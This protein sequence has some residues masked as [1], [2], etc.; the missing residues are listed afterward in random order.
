MRRPQRA[1]APGHDAGGSARWLLTYSD[2]ITLLL[3][4]FVILYAVSKIDAKRYEAVVLAIHGVFKGNT[5]YPTTARGDRAPTPAA[6]RDLGLELMQ[7]L[8]GAL[9]DDLRGGQ[10]EIEQTRRG[11]LVRFQDFCL[12]ERGKAD[13]TKDAKQILG[14]A[15]TVVEPLPYAIEVEGHSDTLPIRSAQ[16]PSNWELSTARATAVV[17]ELIEANG[18]S[19]LRFGARGLGEYKPR[20]PNDPV[21]G[22]PRNRRVELLIVTEEPR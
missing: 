7:Q 11:V 1:V 21:R 13:L 4:F 10:L 9:R 2:M 15:A 18:F 3:A 16:F 14:K 20:F 12:F 17:R 22:E 8:Q 5:P 6:P 19:P